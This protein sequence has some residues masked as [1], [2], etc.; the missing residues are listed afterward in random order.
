MMPGIWR[1]ACKW[2][3][4]HR[5]RWRS[6]RR[7]DT[8]PCWWTATSR[9]YRVRQPAQI[10]RRPCS[11]SSVS[12]SVHGGGRQINVR[13]QPHELAVAAEPGYAPQ[14]AGTLED[15]RVGDELHVLQTGQHAV[16]AVADPH[17]YLDGADIG[18]HKI[19]RNPV[20]GLRVEHGRRHP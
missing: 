8:R 11:R 15:V 5:D 2:P 12:P 10:S 16:L 14:V 6:R 19:F 18:V 3:W 20:R 9:Q 4:N 7:A 13:G 17:A 1:Q